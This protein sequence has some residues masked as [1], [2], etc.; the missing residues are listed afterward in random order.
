VKSVAAYY[1]DALPEIKVG[2]VELMKD[3]TRIAMTVDGGTATGKIVTPS[4]G[5]VAVQMEIE[6]SSGK[7]LSPPMEVT[8]AVE[9][10]APPILFALTPEPKTL[11]ED[12]RK[13][14]PQDKLYPLPQDHLAA[15]DANRKAIEWYRTQLVKPFIE[16]LTRDPQGKAVREAL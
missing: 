9:E 8:I 6:T 7:V 3:A 2:P 16:E 1:R 5:K 11:P 10:I 13:G 14:G 4:K 15:I 12:L